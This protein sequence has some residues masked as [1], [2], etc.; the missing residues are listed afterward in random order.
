MKQK[1]LYTSLDVRNAIIDIFSASKGRRVA[2]TAFVGSGSEAYLPK[3]SGIELVCWPKAG[4]TNPTALKKLIKKGVEVSFVNALHMKIYW[5]EDKGAVLTSANLS[6]NALGAGDLREIGIFLPSKAIDINKILQS[7][8][9][10]PVSQKALA[11]LE[12]IHRDYQSKNKFNSSKTERNSFL[13]WY[14][15]EKSKWK[16]GH[17][18]SSTE[19]S[20]AAKKI[21][22]KEYGLSSPETALSCT[23][24][25]YKRLDWILRF[26]LSSNKPT[27]IQWQ[28]VDYVV[29]IPRS[30]KVY[31]ADYP[32]EAC[33]SWPL[34]RYPPP[35]FKIDDDFRK[36][37]TVALQEF[38]IKKYKD[39][40][41]SKPPKP[42]I[43][44]I[45]ENY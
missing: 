27:S 35:P 8:K 38:G 25:Q 4:G 22:K 23:E 26:R 30:E 19:I 24:N 2:I 16:I 42:L 43:D 32:Y 33:Q 39:G 6:K 20:K 12:K 29:R 13:E 7:I 18:E 1:I 15:L 44:L 31:D 3:P 36:A 37:F 11:A 10:K 21:S 28:P 40:D 34:D 5:T 14:D 45:L 9:P 41:F 17:W